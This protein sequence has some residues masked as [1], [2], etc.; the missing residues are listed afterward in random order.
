[1]NV[2]PWLSILKALE[3]EFDRLKEKMHRGSTVVPDI[4]LTKNKWTV[5]LREHWIVDN[6]FETLA[7]DNLHEA[8][9]W[10]V[11]QLKEWPSVRRT[12]YDVWEFKRR[13]DAEKF[14]ILF[15]IK[16]AR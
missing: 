16:W 3:P 14:Q 5:T 12:A 7:T 11:E 2:D 15:N 13:R 6:D 4:A 1:V 9:S 8:V 10:T